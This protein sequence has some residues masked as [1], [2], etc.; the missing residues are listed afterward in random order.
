MSINRQMVKQTWHILTIKC[1]SGIKWDKPLMSS[2]TDESQKFCAE[3]MKPER[4][5]CTIESYL[6]KVLEQTK[7]MYSDRHLISGYWGRD[8]RGIDYRVRRKLLV[9]M[10]VHYHN[11]SNDYKDVY[12]QQIYLAVLWKWLYFSIY[13]S[14]YLFNGFTYYV[15]YL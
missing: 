8:F 15:N 1:C 12:I 4:R 5:C 6:H 14:M 9:M 11:W 7:L 13:F 2:N 3:W 10:N